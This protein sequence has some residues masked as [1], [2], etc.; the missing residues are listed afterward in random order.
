M[1]VHRFT[2]QTFV[3][4]N[5]KFKSRSCQTQSCH[6]LH[7]LVVQVCYNNPVIHMLDHSRYLFS[8]IHISL[9]YIPSATTHMYLEYCK[10]L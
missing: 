7:L 5:I 2:N 3:L 1:S 8:D 6:L 4:H 9:I 10:S